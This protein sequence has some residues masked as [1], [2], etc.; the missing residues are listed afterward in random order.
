VTLQPNGKVKVQETGY[1]VWN[2]DFVLTNFP[3][4]QQVCPITVR[5]VNYSVD[6]VRIKESKREIYFGQGNKILLF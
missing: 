1:T 6:K 2:C 5:L 4:D 3:N